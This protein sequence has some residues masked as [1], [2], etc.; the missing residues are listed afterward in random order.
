[1]KM[2]TICVLILAMF[3]TTIA[4]SMISTKVEATTNDTYVSKDIQSIVEEISVEYNVCP[5]LILAIIEQES[6]GNQNAVNGD[7]KGLMQVSEKWHKDRMERIGV[8]DLFDQYGNILV[9]TDYLMELA[10]KYDDLYLALMI[11]SGTSDAFE[12]AETYNWT[13]YAE[14]IVKRTMELEEIHGKLN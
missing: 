13:E 2:K 6:S 1:M 14:T 10:N 12:R 7:C 3:A 8:T 4:V 9:G 5:E 11:Y